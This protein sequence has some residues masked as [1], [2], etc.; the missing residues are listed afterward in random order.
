MIVD[1]H[2]HLLGPPHNEN[3]S[4]MQLGNGSTINFGIPR[5]TV[6]AENLIT[7]M[8]KN[9]IDKAII[10]AVSNLI[11]NEDLSKVLI[12]YPSRFI[13]FAKVDDPS[14]SIQAIE[15]LE[16]AVEELGMTGLKLYNEWNNFTLSDPKIVP[17]VKKAA[18]LNI[19]VYCHSAPG[20][21][22]GYFYHNL[23]MHFDAL[24]QRVPEAKLIIGH[25]CNQRFMDLLTL[26]E[27]PNVYTESSWGLTLIADLFGY[28]FL[29]KFV[30]K[31]GVDNLLFGSDWLGPHGE[32]ERQLEL[33]KKLDLTREDKDKIL[34]GN[35]SKLL[36]L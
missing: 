11:S 6:T 22:P 35:I 33:I 12:A 24:N 19:P 29:S 13:G 25:M 34:G 20:S 7:S 26:V 16:Y 8:E 15:Q 27:R 17:L 31:I 21:F 23:P 14:N 3:S 18:E 1:S 5:S 30:R 2:V 9:N 10:V 4:I 32:L 36:N 28:D